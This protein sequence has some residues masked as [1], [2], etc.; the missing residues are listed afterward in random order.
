MLPYY[1]SPSLGVHHY[2]HVFDPLKLSEIILF[3]LA[4]GLI[5]KMARR[6][7][8]F[9]ERETGKKTLPMRAFEQQWQRTIYSVI[10]WIGVILM[11]LDSSFLMLSEL[12]NGLVIDITF[13]PYVVG[14]LLVDLFVLWLWSLISIVLTWLISIL[15][16]PF[17]AIAGG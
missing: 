10:F 4:F 7:T 3:I 15:T 17:R 14:S 8:N 11:L 2:H 12:Q 5:I 16:F 6:F 1:T 9:T 13:S